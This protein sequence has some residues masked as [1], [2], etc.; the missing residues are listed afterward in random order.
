M[1]SNHACF[2]EEEQEQEPVKAAPAV[3]IQIKSSGA[4]K[5]SNNKK[6]TNNN[7]KKQPQQQPKATP[8][9]VVTTTKGNC[10]FCLDFLCSI[11]EGEGIVCQ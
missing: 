3:G 4:N 6:N 9:V 1:F 2:V 8:A 7:T 5:G 10:H 11:V